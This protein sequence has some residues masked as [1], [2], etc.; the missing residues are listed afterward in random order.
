MSDEKTSQFPDATTLDGTELIGVVQGGTNVQTTTYYVSNIV[1]T[2]SFVQMGKYANGG[3]EHGVAIGYYAQSYGPN[4]I[5]IGSGAYSDAGGSI[6]LGYRATTDHQGAIAIGA[7]CYN[8][9]NYAIA[10]GGRA[11]ANG[12]YAIAVGAYASAETYCIAIGYH[13]KGYDTRSIA[14]GVYSK[15]YSNRSIAIG[16]QAKSQSYAGIAIGYNSYAHYKAIAIGVHARASSSYSISIGIGSECLAAYGM[17]IGS[18]AYT[19]G[20]HSIVIGSY[21]NALATKAVALGYQCSARAAYSVAIGARA[22]SEG[23]ASFSLGAYSTSAQDHSMVIGASST[24]T[25][26]G[27][28][29]IGGYPAEFVLRPADHYQKFVGQTIAGVAAVA[30]WSGDGW[31]ITLSYTPGSAGNG[32]FAESLPG[33]S[34][35]QSL[36]INLEGNTMVII[37]GTDSEGALDP[38]KNTV[39]QIAA[40]FPSSGFSFQFTGASDTVISDLALTQLSG[41]VDG[42]PSVILT[43]DGNSPA[44][45]NTPSIWAGAVATLTGRVTGAG[46]NIFNGDDDAACFVLAPLLLYRD[47]DGNYTFVSDATFTLENSTEG[48]VDW[49]VPTLTID[50]DTGFLDITVVNNIETV[51]WMAHFKFETSE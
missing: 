35:N 38:T 13:A 22:E 39:S 29:V 34:V 51:N 5:A 33:G 2:R 36:S 8:H 11:F 18:S 16:F 37:L 7:H 50:G 3:G 30:E 45:N 41:G 25:C 49:D 42:T 44:G 46:P 4:A 26:M 27:S 17:V 10:I 15:A 31:T 14:I 32:F 43:A 9:G 28:L 47:N 40:L 23:Q 6:S 48:A 24:D 20:G 19:I 21:S 1:N 12:A